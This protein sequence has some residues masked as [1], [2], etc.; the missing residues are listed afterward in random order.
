MEMTAKEKAALRSDL[1]NITE[2]A[3]R[4]WGAVNAEP[5]QGGMIIELNSGAFVKVAI[6]V[7]SDEKVDE[8]R[9]EYADVMRRKAEKAELHAQREQIKAQ[10]AAERANKKKKTNEA[11]EK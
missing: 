9:G 5:V 6:S 7:C 2:K 11:E 4:N 10:K 3:I 1:Y 8:W